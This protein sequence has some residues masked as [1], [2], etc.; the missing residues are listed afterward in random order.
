MINVLSISIEPFKVMPFAVSA[1]L[2][3]DYLESIFR[4]SGVELDLS[5]PETLDWARAQVIQG[6]KKSNS[7]YEKSVNKELQKVAPPSSP[8]YERDAVSSLKEE[9]RLTKERL[10]KPG[11]TAAEKHMFTEI[12][13]LQTEKLRTLLGPELRDPEQEV[14]NALQKGL[15]KGGDQVTKQLGTHCA[16]PSCNVL[17]AATDKVFKKCGRCLAVSYCS[18]ECQIPHWK[19]HK[20]VCEKKEPTSAAAASSAAS[21][22]EET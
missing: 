6:Y 19:A 2:Q 8:A 10:Q 3:K 11:I 18:P 14:E 5:N 21:A 16:N 9:I 22:A 1:A 7:V 17:R 15:E 13:T 20:L 4:E 12:L